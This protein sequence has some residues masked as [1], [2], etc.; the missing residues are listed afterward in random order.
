MLKNQQQ[1]G[2]IMNIINK[3]WCRTFQTGFRIAAPFLPYR[4]PE[5]LSSVGDIPKKIKSL[6][7]SSALVVTDEFLYKSGALKSLE[8]ALSDSGVRYHIYSETEPNPSVENVENALSIYNRE[9]LQCIIA[10]GGGSSMDCAKGVG[11]RVAYPKRKFSSL[12]GILKVLRKIPPLFAIPTTAG[13][14]SEV[15]LTAVITD[16]KKKHK[17]TM[18]SFPLIPHFAVLDPEVTYTLPKHLTATTGMD[19][20]THSV[21]AYIGQSTTKETRRLANETVKLVFD[22]IEIAYNDGYDREARENMLHAAYKAGIAFSKSYVGYVHAV[23]HSL[24]GQYGTPHGLANSVLLPVFLESYGECIHKKLYELSLYAGL[25][26]EKDSME[27]GA[28]IFIDA[29]KNLNK[30]MGIPEKIQ[31]IQKEDIPKMASH[32]GKE[33]NPLYPV[34]KLMDSKELE[35]FYYMMID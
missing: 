5:I 11:A 27:K 16:K 15:T 14:G 25:C 26:S 34:P 13:T 9:K 12:K 30:N 33:A 4:E 22:N 18:N 23:A 6:S 7:L 17:Y 8:K 20:L 31:G 10:F 24:G 29:V 32:A 2:C 19:A 21:E 28:K 35:K 1:G 3:I